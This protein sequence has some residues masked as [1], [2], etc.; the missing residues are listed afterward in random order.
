M[1]IQPLPTPLKSKLNPVLYSRCSV[2]MIKLMKWP[3]VCPSRQPVCLP[4]G[5]SL[6]FE[7][8]SP[9]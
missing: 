3:C 9:K 2:N 6:C 7:S 4:G 8:A 1:D 5:Q